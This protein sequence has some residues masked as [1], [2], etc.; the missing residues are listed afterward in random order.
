[1]KGICLRNGMKKT[2]WLKI[3][4]SKLWPPAPKLA[5]QMWEQP[6]VA[7]N[8]KYRYPPGSLQSHIPSPSPTHQLESVADVFWAFQGG[9]YGFPSVP[10]KCIGT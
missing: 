7:R 10:W 3:L 9:G 4:D 6:A 8:M 2:A 1:M 5:F